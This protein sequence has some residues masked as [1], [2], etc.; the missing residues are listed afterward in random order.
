VLSR[1]PEAIKRDRNAIRFRW[2]E[3]VIADPELT[4]AA[5]RFAGL[6]MHRYRYDLQY[7]AV[8]HRAA[9]RMLRM[10]ERSMLRARDLLEERG[11]L[12]RMN[13]TRAPGRPNPT[14]RYALGG[15]PDNL[16]LASP[17]TPMTAGTGDRVSLGA[18]RRDSTYSVID[19]GERPV[20]GFST[21]ED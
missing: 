18:V 6:V 15:G 16:D 2:H 7:A 13:Y 20:L 14:A 4:A 21:N 9:A 3:S 5:L 11:W 10:T 1:T 8:S 17:L 19:S 12:H